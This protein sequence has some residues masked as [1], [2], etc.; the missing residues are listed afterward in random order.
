MTL[1]S[2][3]CGNISLPCRVT[4]RGISYLYEAHLS[5]NSCLKNKPFVSAAKVLRVTLQGMRH[6]VV[7]TEGLSFMTP[8]RRHLVYLYLLR[9]CLSLSESHRKDVEHVYGEAPELLRSIPSQTGRIIIEPEIEK[10]FDFDLQG[11]PGFYCGVAYTVYDALAQTVGLKPLSE[12]QYGWRLNFPKRDG[13][14][15]PYYNEDEL[16]TGLYIYSHARDGAPRLFSSKGLCLGTPAIQPVERT[17]R[18]ID[19]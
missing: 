8:V 14:V 2:Q 3:N 11:V 13:L 5:G 4:R 18:S 10:T 9:E 17:D 15:R 12:K 16:I 6:S 19:A 1:I 7:G